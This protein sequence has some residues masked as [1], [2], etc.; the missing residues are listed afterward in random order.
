MSQ[1]FRV[2]T[3]SYSKRARIPVYP[4]TL[5]V[6]RAL[7]ASRRHKSMLTLTEDC[8]A[9]VLH[10]LL[11]SHDMRGAN[12]CRA[13]RPSL[14]E[15]LRVSAVCRAS[16]LAIS[17]VRE[18]WLRTAAECDAR[19]L[20]RF[21]SVH[22]VSIG[23][24][25][26]AATLEEAMRANPGTEQHSSH[27]GDLQHVGTQ[28]IA[29]ATGSGCITAGPNDK[30]ADAEMARRLPF[31]LC[32]L[33]RLTCLDADFPGDDLECTPQQT[34]VFRELILAV[35][36]A[37]QAGQLRSLRYI[38]HG[39]LTCNPSACRHDGVRALPPESCLCAVLLR[40]MPLENLIAY[41]DSHGLCT[42]KAEIMRA[43]VLRGEPLGK[44]VPCPRARVC[45][46]WCP[47]ECGAHG[48]QGLLHYY[49]PHPTHLTHP[50]H[51]THYSL[52][53]L[54]SLYSLNLL[55]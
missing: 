50:T 9:C 2:Q 7:L 52:N 27:P 30:V 37:R 4:P 51:P 31:A 42:D 6:V 10:A 1:E 43:L 34:H 5:L 33:P 8:W 22:H 25:E 53:S 12:V 11:C 14:C 45:E 28:G 21:T 41:L 40:G 13:S 38:G 23:C 3:L 26:R 39:Y 18:I 32:A 44:P 46:C 19:M 29:P 17:L 35:C 55:R 15:Q 49:T 48:T 16:R 54:H 24:F 36:A 20:A 47:S